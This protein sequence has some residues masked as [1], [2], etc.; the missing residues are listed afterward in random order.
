MSQKKK[1]AFHTC[2]ILSIVLVLAISN[3]ASAPAS[4]SLQPDV[5]DK[6]RSYL[7]EALTAIQNGN[8]FSIEQPVTQD[9]EVISQQ[10]CNMPVGCDLASTIKSG[11]ADTV[12]NPLNE[13][14]VMIQISNFTSS[15]LPLMQANQSLQDL[16]SQYS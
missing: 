7:N 9:N 12:R 3:L 2:G 11:E 10:V 6:I 1:A 15:Q 14:L 8:T 5:V 4:A 13:V 16:L